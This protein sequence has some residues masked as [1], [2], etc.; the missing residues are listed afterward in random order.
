VSRALT[1][2]R[3]RASFPVVGVPGT[4]SAFSTLGAGATSLCISS[5]GCT[6]LT[7]FFL[8]SYP[9]LLHWFVI[10][11]LLCGVLIGSDAVDWFRGRVGL[12]DPA[13]IL[14]VLGV[15][16]FLLAPLLHVA[17][18]Y[19]LSDA[20]PYVDAPPDWRDW[21]GYMAVLNFA[22]LVLY[23]VARD[24]IGTRRRQPSSSYW[25]I[26]L[27]WL[28]FAGVAGLSISA[29]VQYLLYARFGGV[30]G[31]I[32]AF[33]DFAHT[34][35]VA[36]DTDSALAGLGWLLMIAEA[37]PIFAL[38]CFVS[39]TKRKR[40]RPGSLTVVIVLVSFFVARIF[41]GGLHGSRSNT[42]YAL[43]WAAGIIHFCLRP[44]TKKFVL[45][46][47]CFLFA[48]MYVYGFYK[49]MGRDFVTAFQEGTTAAELGED[50]G[51]TLEG[52]VL[53]DFGR[54]DIQAFIL[55][56]LSLP[57]RDY[58]LALGRT[59]LS[60]LAQLIPRG[61]WP[62]RPPNTRKEGTEIQYGVGSYDPHGWASARVFGIAGEA[63]LNF[64]PFAVPFAYLVFGI[65]VGGVR[66]FIWRLDQGDT[67][68][69][70]VPF[71]ITLCFWL[72]LGD[73]DTFLFVMIKD[74][75]PPALLVWIG[76]N[77][78]SSAATC[79]EQHSQ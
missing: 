10:P 43:F 29:V 66:R 44:M 30:A 13:G 52:L 70:L 75:L 24:G 20:R 63:M 25:R 14:G 68:L 11:T 12:F 35:D 74:G 40:F 38:I 17:W 2:R 6:L 79:K 47:I 49:S 61:V 3:G 48:Y 50:T 37:F 64:G 34:I 71:L 15:H 27:K 55:Y 19:W 5:I 76:S 1:I 56:R 77:C 53:G 39:W 7:V 9:Q 32:D 73:S 72:L 57:D 28:F 51:R 59:Y 54:T 23:R 45:I 31:F 78:L 22:G 8:V 42:L 16:F 4:T 60:T 67:R 18:Q 62:D 58:H 26:N 21:L 69:L 65:V 33:T 36:D 41:F 46:G